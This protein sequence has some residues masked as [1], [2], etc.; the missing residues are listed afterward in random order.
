MQR[1]ESSPPQ[2]ASPCPL[3]QNGVVGHSGL[4]PDL[5]VNAVGSGRVPTRDEARPTDQC[6]PVAERTGHH[7][8]RS[9]GGMLLT[10]RMPDQ[11]S[12]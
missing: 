5:T 11:R 3:R 1:F 2:P 8:R 12:N 6:G 10:I 9:L 4:S 7:G